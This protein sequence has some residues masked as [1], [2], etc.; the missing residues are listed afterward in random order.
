MNAELFRPVSIRDP[1]EDGDEEDDD[2][3][4]IGAVTT[5]YKCPLT[6]AYLDKPVKRCVFR[7]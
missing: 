6:A 7:R 1:T 2:E 3:M 5:S 4:E